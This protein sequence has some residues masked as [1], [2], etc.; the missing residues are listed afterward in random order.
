MDQ[1]GSHIITLKEFELGLKKLDVLHLKRKD[2]KKL[3]N[4]LDDDRSG[5]VTCEEL[6]EELYPNRNLSGAGT[7]TNAGRRLRRGRSSLQFEQQVY[8]RTAVKER[9][10][11]RYAAMCS[12]KNDKARAAAKNAGTVRSPR[13]GARRSG[14]VSPRPQIDDASPRR[15]RKKP[16]PK[17]DA[18]KLPAL[19]S[20][21]R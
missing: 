3:F 12:R 9:S 13:P 8:S 11:A 1:D 15:A 19:K 20:P 18:S 21:T 5:R 10:N 17:K 7:M 16:K 14:A 6:I 4:S 2:Y